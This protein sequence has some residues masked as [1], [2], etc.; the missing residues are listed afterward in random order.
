MPDFK[1]GTLSFNGSLGG[2]W[3]NPRQPL[4]PSRRLAAFGPIRPMEEPGL[5]RRI[6]GR[7]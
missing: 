4:D 3:N 5:L 7:A 6:F 2:N 1:P